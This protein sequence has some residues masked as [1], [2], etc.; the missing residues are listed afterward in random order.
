MPLIDIKNLTLVYPSKH[1]LEYVCLDDLNVSFASNSINVVIG[2]S[3]SG[4]SSLLKAIAGIYPY[5]GDIYFDKTNVNKLTPGSRK[6]SFI[7]QEISLY[8]NL[9]I[10]DNI[11]LPLKIAKEKPEFI[12]EKVF[13]IAKQFEI[14]ST[15]SRLPRY[16]SLGQQQIVDIAKAFVKKPDI[17]L[18]DEPFSNIDNKNR[19]KGR[20]LI[21]KACLENKITSIFVTHLKEDVFSLADFVYILENGKI[22][23]SL[24]KEEIKNCNHPLLTAM[25]GED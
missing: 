14:D 8:P 6:L 21:K 2:E 16:I 3:G 18:F 24:K 17:I 9:T 20:E 11:A 19:E 15:L 1:N 22:V 12:R 23:K 10:F 4:K 13:S 25:M 5:E 7:P